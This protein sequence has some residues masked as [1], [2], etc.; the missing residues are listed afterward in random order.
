MIAKIV[1]LV[2]AALISAFAGGCGASLPA[3]P[4]KM[5]PQQ[6]KEWVKDKT[7]YIFCGTAN[8]P[9]GKGVGTYV[10][11]DKGVAPNTSVTVEGDCKT[12][13]INTTPAPPK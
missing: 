11:I 12:T 1:A 10:S 6:I 5:S 4:S 9:W 8:S 2:L 7:D 13:I 3:N